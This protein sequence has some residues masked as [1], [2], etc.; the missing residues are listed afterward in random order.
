MKDPEQNAPEASRESEAGN[1][2]GEG[3]GEVA[4]CP[5]DPPDASGGSTGERGNIP[6]L[7]G[8]VTTGDLP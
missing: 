7:A 4:S 3:M 2:N 1:Q 8:D 5:Q 6:G